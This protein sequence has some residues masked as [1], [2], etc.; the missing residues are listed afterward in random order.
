MGPDMARANLSPFGLL[1]LYLVF[2]TS[3]ILTVTAP[4]GAQEMQRDHPRDESVHGGHGGSGIGTGI[5]I[6]VGIGIVNELI[7]R[8][9][10]PPDES[11]PHSKGKSIRH[12]TELK[13]HKRTAKKDDRTPPP[14]HRQTTDKP[15][16]T[17]TTDSPPQP[18][19][20]GNPPPT[21]A[22]GTPPAQPTGTPPPTKSNPPGANN[23]PTAANPQQPI[24]PPAQTAKEECPQRG[25]GCVALLID[26]RKYAFVN[27]L[28]DVEEMDELG[29]AEELLLRTDCS[30]ERIS[31][32]IKRTT[33]WTRKYAIGAIRSTI[34]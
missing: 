9:G 20:T 2:V 8:Q 26:F 18:N 12:K 31:P 1:T 33:S 32:D 4:V 25:R 5:G 24:A 11:M 3:I 27:G 29:E 23:P 30:V 14:K 22:T 21:Q 16:P 7:R 19:A 15:P 34:L 10:A 13:T 17:K 6:G 28:N